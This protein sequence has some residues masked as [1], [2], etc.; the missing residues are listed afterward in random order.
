MFF[1][2]GLRT[3]LHLLVEIDGLAEHAYFRS[4]VVRSVGITEELI[5]DLLKLIDECIRLLRIG[6]TAECVD[7]PIESGEFL[8]K[9]CEL[10]FLLLSILLWLRWC[11]HCYVW[12][13]SVHRVITWS[14]Q[15]KHCGEGCCCSSH[16]EQYVSHLP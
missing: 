14:L 5:A 11:L 15:Q 16:I 12:L 4:H 2:I 10:G 7:S 9:R 13:L 8:L 3:C 1:L 6:A